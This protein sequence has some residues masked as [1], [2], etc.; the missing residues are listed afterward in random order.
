ML[1]IFYVLIGHLY[2]VFYEL[3]ISIFCPFGGLSSELKKF[4]IYSGCIPILNTYCVFTY[5]SISLLVKNIWYFHW[6]DFNITILDKQFLF[7]VQR[8]LLYHFIL[9]YLEFG[10]SELKLWIKTYRWTQNFL[11][12]LT[13]NYVNFI[14]NF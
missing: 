5:Y 3:F 10:S 9:L 2:T 12:F 13:I 1:S 11:I 4:F 6:G 8:S 14:V 7:C